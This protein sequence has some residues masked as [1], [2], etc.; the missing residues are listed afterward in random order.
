MIEYIK[1]TPKEIESLLSIRIE[2][3]E[4]VNN[5]AADY[6]FDNQFIDNS[7]EYFESDKHITILAKE[8]NL[9]IGCASMCLIKVMPTFDHPSCNRAHIMN[10]Y[11]KKEYRGRGIAYHAM[12]ELITEAKKLKITELSL[13]STKEGRYLYRKCGFNES[14]EGLVLELK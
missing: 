6:Q 13:D 14:K 8:G 1:A 9:I 4:E 5:L 7:K 2:M 10:V 11:T 12:Q 3:L